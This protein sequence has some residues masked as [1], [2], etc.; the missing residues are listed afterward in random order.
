MSRWGWLAPS[1][2]CSAGLQ[3]KRGALISQHCEELSNGIMAI[4]TSNQSQTVKMCTPRSGTDRTD[5]THPLGFTHFPVQ[6]DTDER[7][8]N[9]CSPSGR[10]NVL[11]QQHPGRGSF[12]SVRALRSQ[13]TRHQVALQVFFHQHPPTSIP[14]D[15]VILF[16]PS[17]HMAQTGCALLSTHRRY[18]SSVISVSYLES[19]RSFSVSIVESVWFCR[20]QA[21]PSG[22]APTDVHPSW[23]LN[24][25][26]ALAVIKSYS[27]HI[28]PLLWSYKLLTFP[29][30]E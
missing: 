7:C 17:S 26:V 24:M 3:A 5:V 12:A 15:D 16:R 1:W 25:A 23:L 30:T 19:R 13:R 22:Y 29:S 6:S 27:H 20:L 2:L 4:T 14:N 8:C 18:H 28:N 21:L 10:T 9:S 11:L